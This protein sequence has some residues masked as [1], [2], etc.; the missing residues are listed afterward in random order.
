MNCRRVQ[1]D[2]AV[3]QVAGALLVTLGSAA[4]GGTSL[5]ALSHRCT[6]LPLRQASD[7]Q[8]LA[9]WMGDLSSM[10]RAFPPT[11][12]GN[13]QW[14][15]PGPAWVVGLTPFDPPRPAHP[16]AESVGTEAL[17]LLRADLMDLPP[18]VSPPV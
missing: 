18:P 13:G 14:F 11:Q 12:S 6:I 15:G 1:L 9:R 7:R 3:V 4:E 5:A 10:V 8:A 16:L 2:R 17:T